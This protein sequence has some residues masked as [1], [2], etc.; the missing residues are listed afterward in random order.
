M[1]HERAGVPLLRLRR[2]YMEHVPNRVE[3]PNSLT[4]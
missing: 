3:K 2:D 1:N 4:I